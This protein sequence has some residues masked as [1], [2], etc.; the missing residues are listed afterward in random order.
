MIEIPDPPTATDCAAC[1][2]LTWLYSARRSAWVAFVGAGDQ[3]TIRPHPCRHAQ[4]PATWRE[5]R[6]PAPP[7]PEYLA[8]KAALTQEQ[9][10]AR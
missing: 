7:S 5:I 9:S 2:P 10:H 1:G 3:H 6:Q 8:A 4:E